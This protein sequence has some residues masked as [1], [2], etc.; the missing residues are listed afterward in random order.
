MTAELFSRIPIERLGW[1][2]LHFLWQGTAISLLYAALRSVLGWSLSAQGRYLLASA[3]LLLLTAAP[4]LT[5]AMNPASEGPSAFTL[6]VP[7]P[8]S[9]PAYNNRIPI[10][11]VVGVPSAR[12]GYALYNSF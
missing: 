9:A 4:F 8:V 11:F 6:R 12:R 10:G 5:F 2:L 3:A 7:Q 1:T